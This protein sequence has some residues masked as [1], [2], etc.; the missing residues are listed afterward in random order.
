M[1]SSFRMNMRH[2]T[3]SIVVGLQL[4]ALATLSCA[5]SAPPVLELAPGGFSEILLEPG[6]KG[7]DAVE[8]P[9]R[10]LVGLHLGRA[11]GR[12]RIDEVGALL[13]LVDTPDDYCV[14]I[15]SADRRYSAL[16]HYE[17]STAGSPAMRVEANSRY[18]NELAEQFLA[19]DMVV[20]IA[21]GSSCPGASDSLIVAAVPPGAT[22][23][24]E[25]LAYLNVRGSQAQISLLH[26]ENVLA[27]GSCERPDRTALLYSDVCVVT[28]PAPNGAA[29]DV[30]RVTYVNNAGRISTTDFHMIWRR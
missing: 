8:D 15:A 21:S 23:T 6:V 2:A 3:C 20:R 30:L 11:A 14:R 27:V 19:S 4:A 18:A 1:G 10:M 28:A 26:A 12:F 25:L 13:P 17:K 5:Q 22:E 9:L 29:P 24:R 16:N 7:R